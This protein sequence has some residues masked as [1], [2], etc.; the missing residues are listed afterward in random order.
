VTLEDILAAAAAYLNADTSD[1]DVGSVNLGLVALNQS[2]N[3]ALLQHDFE[4]T[5]ELA[6]LTVSSAAGQSLESLVLFDTTDAVG[7][8]TIVEVGE[9]VDDVLVP[10][11]WTTVAESIERQRF[12]VPNVESRVVLSGNRVRIFPW[13]DQTHRL[14]F[15]IYSM[16]AEWVA[17]DLEDA[18]EP[19]STKGQ[20]FLLWQTIVH[21]NHLKKEF[22]FR[23]E[24]NLPPPKDLALEGLEVFKQWDTFKYEQFRRHFRDE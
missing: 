9:V 23:Q 15:E 18:F 24:G 19:W 2:R 14:W 5:R 17:A 11:E 7:H 13:D 1:F 21:L 22:V 20:Q 16:P 4:F 6:E 12:R 3:F 8:K 10:V